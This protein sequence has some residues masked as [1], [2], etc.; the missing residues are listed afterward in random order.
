MIEV[1]ALFVQ[2]GGAYW[3][4]PWIDPWDEI[5]DARHYAGPY[6]VVAHPPCQR[7]SKM[8]PLVQSL[9][10]Y[11]CK[12]DGGCFQFTLDALNRW[13]GVLEHPASSTAW[14]EFGIARP[15]KGCWMAT[16]NGWTCEVWQSAYGHKA[17]KPTWLYYVGET[18]PYS[19]RW[20]R[21]VSNVRVCQARNWRKLPTL[22]RREADASPL[23]FRN[24]LVKIALHS[25]LR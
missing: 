21:P 16:L 5:A 4:L 11:K 15:I 19:L 2:R 8:A 14:K 1:A 25:R 13:G 7:W 24:E 23:S 12:D 17:E 20:E 3:N 6:P 10:G 9:Y 18:A 22:S